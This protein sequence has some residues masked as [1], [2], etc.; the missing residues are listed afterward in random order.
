MLHDGVCGKNSTHPGP[1]S[2]SGKKPRISATRAYR[3]Y[4]ALRL[5][6]EDK[7]LGYLHGGGSAKNA[8]TAPRLPLF[9]IHIMV[10][11]KYQTL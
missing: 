3:A 5:Y 10:V 8:D 2:G 7:G 4:S 9:H 6:A 1:R 11:C